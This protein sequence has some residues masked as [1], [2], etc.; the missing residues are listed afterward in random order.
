[1]VLQKVVEEGHVEVTDT[2]IDDNN[3][4]IQVGHGSL[5]EVIYPPVCICFCAIACAQLRNGLKVSCCW[6]HW[7]SAMLCVHSILP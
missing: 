4:A 2:L 6:L 1:M 5:P 7:L 3:S